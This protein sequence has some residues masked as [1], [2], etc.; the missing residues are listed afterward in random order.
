MQSL[1]NMSE[2]SVA[3]PRLSAAVSDESS[4]GDGKH[5]STA[6][7]SLGPLLRLGGVVPH[8]LNGPK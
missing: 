2:A 7:P 6:R 1:A 3:A 8:G 4:G 5:D